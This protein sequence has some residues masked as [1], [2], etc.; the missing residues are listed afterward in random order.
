[1][2]TRGALSVRRG[3]NILLVFVFLKA[4]ATMFVF[5]L[6]SYADC[7]MLRYF[8]QALDKFIL[9]MRAEG[10]GRRLEM[11]IAEILFRRETLPKIY[12]NFSSKRIDPILKIVSK[13]WI[14]PSS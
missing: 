6:S 9:K 1:M 10:C 11:L 12:S 3:I 13:N 4:A 7:V 8:F 5:A 14:N 2:R